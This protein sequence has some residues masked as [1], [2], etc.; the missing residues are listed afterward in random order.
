M[1]KRGDVSTQEL[2]RSDP[3]WLGRLSAA[4]GEAVHPKRDPEHVREDL[5]QT[6]AAFIASPVPSEELRVILRKYLR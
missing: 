6:L 1:G 3:F 2:E 5:R 4:I